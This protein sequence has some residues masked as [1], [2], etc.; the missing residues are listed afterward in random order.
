MACCYSHKLSVFAADGSVG[1]NKLE[2]NFTA[3]RQRK[4]GRIA[5]LKTSRKYPSD[6]GKQSDEIKVLNV[7]SIHVDRLSFSHKFN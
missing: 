3:K 6:N 5:E 1:N 7:T 4:P 2:L